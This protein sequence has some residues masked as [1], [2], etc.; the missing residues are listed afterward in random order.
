VYKPT[1]HTC[2]YFQAETLVSVVRH[3]HTHIHIYIKVKFILGQ[4]TKARRG[5]R[6]KLYSIFNL[7]ARWGGW[8]TPRLGRFTSGK[9]PVPIVYKAG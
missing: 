7:G 2:L 6:G 4:A 8:P 3:T 1:V 9:D 5:S